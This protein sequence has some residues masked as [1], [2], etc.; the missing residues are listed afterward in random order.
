MRLIVRS[1]TSA[2][3]GAGD[4]G[5]V[6][7]VSRSSRSDSAPTALVGVALRALW[8]RGVASSCQTDV[9]V[10]HCAHWPTRGKR[11][12]GAERPRLTRLLL[13]DE[14][15][16][17][18]RPTRPRA[19]PGEATEPGSRKGK[20]EPSRRLW[21]CPASI[22]LGR[23]NRSHTAAWRRQV[24][25]TVPTRVGGSQDV[26]GPCGSREMLCTTS[27]VSFS[28]ACRATSAWETTP[29]RRSSLPVTARRLT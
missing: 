19:L 11:R 24:P 22:R 13:T 3:V 8:P 4:P 20:P 18:G 29:T 26:R 17:R 23:T 28:F 2:G 5:G 7:M 16:K 6:G 14:Q 25:R 10:E 9:S 21:I 27:P 1:P 12:G 15:G